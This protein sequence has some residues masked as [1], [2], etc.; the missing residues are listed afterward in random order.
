[1]STK[2]RG[3]AAILAGLFLSGSVTMGAGGQAK[4]RKDD[5]PTCP[6]G[7]SYRLKT[8]PTKEH[9]AAVKIKGKTYFACD[10]CAKMLKQKAA[11][12]AAAKRAGKTG[13][14]KK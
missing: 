8:T 6:A 13:L 11:K 10:H 14:K 4:A 12:K 3:A 9:P 2:L 7:G 1:L 5:A